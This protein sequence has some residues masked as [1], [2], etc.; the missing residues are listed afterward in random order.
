[1]NYLRVVILNDLLVN[2][3]KYD[4]IVFKYNTEINFIM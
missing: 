2:L 1:M 4:K 3:T